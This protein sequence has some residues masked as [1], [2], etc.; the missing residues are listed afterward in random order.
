MRWGNSYVFFKLHS[1]GEKQKEE[2]D[3]FHHQLKNATSILS[4]DVTVTI[5]SSPNSWSSKKKS[6][7]FAKK[8]SS[9]R[10]LP[11]S[12]RFSSWVLVALKCQMPPSFSRLDPAARW[13]HAPPR[14]TH[15][16]NFLGSLG[17]EHFSGVLRGGSCWAKVRRPS[18]PAPH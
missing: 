7:V 6:N 14:A 3:S 16:M 2:R 18:S 4:K 1:S 11:D 9:G 5:A 17:T 10:V 8:K 12:M 13:Q 15:A